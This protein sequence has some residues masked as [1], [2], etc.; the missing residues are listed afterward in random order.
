MQIKPMKKR[1]AKVWK[2]TIQVTGARTVDGS[3][4]CSAERNDSLTN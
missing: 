1:L 2:N 4:V 3:Q